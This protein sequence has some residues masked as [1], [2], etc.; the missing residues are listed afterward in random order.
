MN[1][2]QLY[3]S[4]L[5]KQS[6]HGPECAWSGKPDHHSYSRLGTLARCPRDRHPRTTEIPVVREPDL[7][8]PYS[9][10]RS[11]MMPKSTLIII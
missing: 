1:I 9:N 3:G 2:L 11:T 8:S 4:D 5:E 7:R 6:H 10:I